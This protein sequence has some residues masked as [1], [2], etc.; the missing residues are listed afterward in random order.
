VKVPGVKVQLAKNV[1]VIVV[2]P[3][4]ITV[5]EALA[6]FVNI[7]FPVGLAAHPEKT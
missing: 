6:A 1:G 3:D 7:A 5:V 2:F 4:R